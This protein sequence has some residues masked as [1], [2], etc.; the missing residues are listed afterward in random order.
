M[1]IEVMQLE[2]EVRT[3]LSLARLKDATRK[4]TVAEQICKRDGW[5]NLMQ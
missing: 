1:V 4:T 3:L 5:F 2:K